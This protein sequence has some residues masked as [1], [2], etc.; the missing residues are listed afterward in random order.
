MG[1]KRIKEIVNLLEKDP[2]LIDSLHYEELEMLNEYAA[3]EV[4]K[5]RKQRRR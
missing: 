4:I 3:K 5:L 2:S 1:E